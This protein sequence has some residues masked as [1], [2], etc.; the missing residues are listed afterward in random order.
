MALGGDPTVIRSCREFGNRPALIVLSTGWARLPELPGRAFHSRTGSH[1]RTMRKW[2]PSADRLPAGSQ[3]VTVLLCSGNFNGSQM[4]DLS[5]LHIHLGHLLTHS[6]SGG[7]GDIRQKCGTTPGWRS[8]SKPKICPSRDAFDRIC[9]FLHPVAPLASINTTWQSPLPSNTTSRS[10]S[11]WLP[12]ITCCSGLSKILPHR[13]TRR[14]I[15]QQSANPDGN[16][17]P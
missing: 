12:L 4:Y 3:R 1:A 11:S 9:A 15:A 17:L 16:P 7:R 14:R 13:R 6:C 2:L 5:L 10:V 8:P